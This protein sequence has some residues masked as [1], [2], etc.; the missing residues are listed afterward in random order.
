[1]LSEKVFAV[2]IMSNCKRGVLYIGVTSN[3]VNRVSEHRDGTREGF[4]KRYKLTRLVWYGGFD[5][6]L[7]PAGPLK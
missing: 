4:T 3:L 1:M 6:A 7:D 2:Y 5:D